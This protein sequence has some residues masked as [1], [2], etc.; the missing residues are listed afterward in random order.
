MIGHKPVEV[1]NIIIVF[2]LTSVPAP[3]ST[4]LYFCYVKELSAPPSIYSI[5][6]TMHLLGRIRYL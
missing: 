2:D 3:I 4:P 1:K 5:L 6:C